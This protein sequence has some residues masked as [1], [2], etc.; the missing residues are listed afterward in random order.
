MERGDSDADRRRRTSA[1]AKQIS[2]STNQGNKKAGEN[3]CQPDNRPNEICH[4]GRLD[5]LP[6]RVFDQASYLMK[7]S[8]GRDA[9][10]LGFLIAQLK[11][12]EPGYRYQ[13]RTYGSQEIL[14][15]IPSRVWHLFGPSPALANSALCS[16]QYFPTCFANPLHEIP[17]RSL[18]SNP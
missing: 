16:G 18:L 13:Y 15:C 9:F 2:H 4:F 10:N 5:L 12:P 17:G 8:L 6:D 7:A 14:D 1:P 11:I 3:E